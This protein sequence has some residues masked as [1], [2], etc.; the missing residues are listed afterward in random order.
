MNRNSFTICTASLTPCRER[1]S[2][3]SWC[4]TQLVLAA[5][6][7]PFKRRAFPLAI[8]RAETLMKKKGATF[9]KQA[10]DALRISEYSSDCLLAT[11]K[12]VWTS[13]LFVF[14]HC[15]RRYSTLSYNFTCGRQS[16]RAS[17][18]TR[19]TPMGTVTC[20]SSKLGATLVLRT[21]RPTLSWA[22]MAIWR[23]PTAKLLSLTDDRLRRF[24]MAEGKRPG[25]RSNYGEKGNCG[26]VRNVV[27]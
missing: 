23:R 25:Q 9:Q 27:G 14:P 24:N 6:L 22:A 4:R 21:T 17:K 5:S 7:P 26:E 2:W 12:Q 1:A 11:E 15:L 10:F 18:M 20:S 13:H 8:A 16:G 19:R 3:V